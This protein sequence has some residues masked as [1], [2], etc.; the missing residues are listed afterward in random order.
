MGFA[1]ELLDL[2]EDLTESQAFRTYLVTEPQLWAAWQ[3][4]KQALSRLGIFSSDQEKKDVLAKLADLADAID[5]NWA[6]NV[7]LITEPQLFV[8]WKMFKKMLRDTMRVLGR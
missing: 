5:R 4:T 1:G 7:W 8:A 3:A 6:F 2:M